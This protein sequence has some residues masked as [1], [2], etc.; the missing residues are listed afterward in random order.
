MALPTLTKRVRTFVNSGDRST[1][2]GFLPVV[3]VP[4]GTQLPKARCPDKAAP[5]LE[6]FDQMF[7]FGTFREDGTF[8]AFQQDF[9]QLWN[10]SLRTSN[11]CEE[12]N[13]KFYHLVRHQHPSIRKFIRT[14]Q[15]KETVV[16]AVIAR[17]S[18]GERPRKKTN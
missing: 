16:S 6:Y 13:N 9:L 8:V 10:V 17:D 14:I 4:E 2:L 12:Q 7:V 11:L 18:V 15:Q 5:P 3:D 1:S